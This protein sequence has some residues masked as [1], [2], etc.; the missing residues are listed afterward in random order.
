MLTSTKY[1]LLSK[2]L[3]KINHVNVW[4]YDFAFLCR[5]EPEVDWSQ[6]RLIKTRQSSQVI[7]SMDVV[8]SWFWNSVLPVF[9]P[10]CSL[11]I[12]F[13]IFSITGSDGK[14]TM[15]AIVFMVLLV[16]VVPKYVFRTVRL[17]GLDSEKAIL[18]NSDLRFISS[19]ENINLMMDLCE[20]WWFWN[21]ASC[22]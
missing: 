16:S 15:E 1:V 12:V 9:R 3:N 8:A 7:E 10:G 4:I 22:L 2:M 11:L 14:T 19:L 18:E 20:W 21:Q 13:L 5:L 17:D 6:M